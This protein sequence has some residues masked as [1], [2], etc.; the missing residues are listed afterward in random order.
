[1]NRELFIEAITKFIAGVLLVAILLFLPAGS[2][3]Y[4]NA[5]Y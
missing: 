1:M 3:A 5:G 2:F 4:W